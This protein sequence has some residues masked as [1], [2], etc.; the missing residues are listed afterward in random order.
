MWKNLSMHALLRA[1]FYQDELTNAFRLF[2]G[3]GDVLGGLTIDFYNG[4]AVFSWYNQ[5]I[6]SQKKSDC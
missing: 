3:E 5:F 6:Y 1:N 2:N 4:F